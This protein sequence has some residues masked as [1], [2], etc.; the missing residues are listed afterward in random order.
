VERAAEELCN[1]ASSI[2]LFTSYI[3]KIS[4]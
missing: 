4:G 2:R 3:T 1:D